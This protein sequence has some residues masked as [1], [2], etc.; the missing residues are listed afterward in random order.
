MGERE[1]LHSLQHILDN[2]ENIP[3]RTGTNCISVFDVNLSFEVNYRGPNLYQVPILTTKKI[4]TKGI[5][6]ELLWFLKG[7]TNTNWLSERGVHFWDGNTSAETL[8]NLN[9]PY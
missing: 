2:G 9:L 6:L 8:A 4:Y 7:L 3:S 1:Y 5:I